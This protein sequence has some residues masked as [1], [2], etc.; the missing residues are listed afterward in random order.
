[1]Y[2]LH[3]PFT[4]ILFILD[5]TTANDPTLSTPLDESQRTELYSELASGAETGRIFPDL[6]L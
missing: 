5:Y 3:I 6:L 1:M 2:C 4:N